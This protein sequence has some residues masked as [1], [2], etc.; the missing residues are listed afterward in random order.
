MLAGILLST[1]GGRARPS[2]KPTLTPKVDSVQRID[3]KTNKLVAT[4]G[5]IGSNPDA[6][7]VGAGSVWVGSQEDG[8]VS[9]VDA[10]TNAVRGSVQT[11]G[12]VA[13]AVRDGSV[14][15]GNQGYGM[16]TIDPATMDV[17]PSQSPYYASFAQGGGALWALVGPLGTRLDRI[18]HG[19]QIVKTFTTLG[20]DPFA[21]SADDHGVWVLDDV[22]RT[23]F[24]VDPATDRVVGRI[25]LGFDPGW[26]AVGGGSVWVTDAGGGAVVRIDPR[27]DR[28]VGRIRVGRDPQ[29]VVVA[30]GAAW[31]ANYEDGTVSRIDLRSGAVT[32]IPVGRYPATL[33]TGGA[34]VWVPVRGA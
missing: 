17:S 13:I 12:P 24:R 18:N 11:G 1:G 6:I 33:A 5:G 32:T 4:I 20:T 31:V 23:L 15:V 10:R 14:L 29:G 16:T 34:G 30:Y 26:V 25:P 9:R 22:S 28:V 2:T 21:V 27:S 8:T 7:A 19:L 3:P